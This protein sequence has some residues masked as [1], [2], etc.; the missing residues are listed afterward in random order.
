MSHLLSDRR[1]KVLAGAVVAATAASQWSA[2]T[3]EAAPLFNVHLEG[4]L[5][6]SGDPFSTTVTVTP[7]SVIEYQ[8]V[9]NIS[10]IGTINSSAGNITITSLTSGPDGVQTLRFDAF[11]LATQDIQVNI[12]NT[13]AFQNGWGQV[14][15][16][17]P[18][19]QVARGNGNTDVTGIRP[20][21]NPGVF[22][23][24]STEVILTGTM[25]V[26][27]VGGTSASLVNVRWSSGTG[28]VHVNG[29]GLSK[30]PSAT[31]EA[32]ANPVLSYAGLTL[33]TNVVPEPG[34]ISLLGLAGLGLLARR[35]KA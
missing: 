27:S 9:G 12:P 24:I 1:F 35:R 2:S 13:E 25:S 33:V 17:S 21:H 22:S 15:D 7:T 11:E 31:T 3:A 10:P 18:G 26:V 29:T 34:S 16:A 8:L 23:A 5:Q 20:G 4:R 28:A 32:G 14:S 19:V 6:G 30:F